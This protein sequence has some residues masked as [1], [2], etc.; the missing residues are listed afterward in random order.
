ML[1]PG[2]IPRLPRWGSLD[3]TTDGPTNVWGS[4]GADSLN[5][6]VAIVG[7]KI[8]KA[9]DLDARMTRIGLRPRGAPSGAS[10]VDVLRLDVADSVLGLTGTQIAQ[11]RS[12]LGGAQLDRVVDI[13]AM[14][15]DVAR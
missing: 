5:E 8:Q 13:V 2:E 3:Q 6:A 7:S 4:A 9:G 15:E 14:F 12:F 10:P 11:V 1:L